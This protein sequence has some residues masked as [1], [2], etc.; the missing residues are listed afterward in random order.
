MSFR[1]AKSKFLSI[2][3]QL[4][5]YHHRSL[6]FRCKLFAAMI[7]ANQEAQECEYEILREIAKE[8]YKE[9]EYRIEIM[10][11]ITKEYVSKIISHNTFTLDDLLIEIDRE[12]KLN[13]RFVHKIN[14]EHLRRLICEG[15]EENQLIQNRI[16]EF[17]ESEINNRSQN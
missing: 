8:F 2:F 13:R 12:L 14:L 9:D 10:V 1:T 4:F 6:E 5:V 7:V 15:N 11:N 3:R 17:L 16:L